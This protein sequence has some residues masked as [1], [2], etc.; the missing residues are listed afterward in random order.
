MT[1]NNLLKDIY[2]L[3]VQKQGVSGPTNLQSMPVGDVQLTYRRFL[4]R[5]GRTFFL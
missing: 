5:S 1:R 3:C 4:A 2:N